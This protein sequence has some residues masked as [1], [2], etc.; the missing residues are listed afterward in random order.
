MNT[1]TQ[2]KTPF[3]ALN[4]GIHMPAQG[5]ARE[6]PNHHLLVEL[7]SLVGEWQKIDFKSIF[8]DSIS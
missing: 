2:S 8:Q 3:V 6:Y 4:N 7:P 1:Q 5:E